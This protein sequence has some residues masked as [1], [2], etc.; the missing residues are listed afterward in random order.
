MS[1]VKFSVL[2]WGGPKPKGDRERLI[3]LYGKLWGIDITLLSSS[4]MKKGRRKIILAPLRSRIET[5]TEIKI[6]ESRLR[7]EAQRDR[8]LDSLEKEEESQ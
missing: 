7:L 6:I 4:K 3:S 8:D 5:V 2:K 1:L